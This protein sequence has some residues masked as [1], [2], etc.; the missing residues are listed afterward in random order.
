MSDLLKIGPYEFKSRLLLGTGKFNDLNIQNLAVQASEADVLTFAIRRLPIDNPEA[1]NFLE[2]LDLKKFTLLPNTAGAFTVEEAVRIAKLARATGLCDMIKVEVI[3]DPRTLLP[4]PIGTLEAT[5]ILVDL[6]FIVLPYTSDDPILA[7][8]LQEAGA[9][10]V[11][12]GAS[13]IGSGQGIVNPNQLRFIIEE[14]KVPVIIDAGIGG[15]ADAALAMELGADG[16]LLNTA[17]SGAQDPVLMA[18]AFKLAVLAGRKGYLAG[19]IV[20]KRY[21]SAS[22]PNEGMIE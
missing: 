20:K 4:D 19:R 13:P 21:A 22:S 5:K 9:A 8:K 18:E 12:P 15:P 16:V 17:V 3:G 14:A 1:P 2:T 6:G 11:M 7:R 10:A